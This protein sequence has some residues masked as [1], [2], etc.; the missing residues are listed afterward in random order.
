VPEN[1]IARAAT[2]L[3]FGQVDLAREVLEIVGPTARASVRY[4]QLAGGLAL[5]EKQ[6][7]VAESHFA[8]ALELEPNNLQF[9][10]NLAS[11]RLASPNVATNEKARADLVRLESLRALAADA[12]A[13]N[14]RVSAE[15]WASQLK[16]EK[17]VTF[18]DALLYLEATHGSDGAAAALLEAQS[19]ANQSPAT[20]AGLITWMNR[21]GLAKS[22]LEWALSLPKQ[23]SDAQP[24]P[25]AIAESSSFL[26][27]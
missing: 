4:H 13:R 12:L 6:P 17:N 20:A 11:V 7:D 27:D 18:P 2:A 14:S 3:R 10:L 5:A 24:V 16:A 9:A 22:A 15:Q 23:T 26:Q 8:A 19:K 1:L 21:H 25:L